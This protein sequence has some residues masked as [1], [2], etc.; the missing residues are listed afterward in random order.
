MLYWR[1]QRPERWATISP[2]MRADVEQY[3]R[4]KQA[5][6]QEQERDGGEGIGRGRA[7]SA[8]GATS[9]PHSSTLPCMEV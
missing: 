2:A 6:A 9:G 7:G 8:C 5:T 1:A 4:E 3:A